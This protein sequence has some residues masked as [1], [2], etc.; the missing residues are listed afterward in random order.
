MSRFAV[1]FLL[2]AAIAMPAPANAATPKQDYTSAY[3]EATESGKPLVV[4]VGTD[5]C[6]GCVKMKKQ[7]IPQMQ[8]KGSLSAVKFTE[9]NAED[10]DQLAAKLMSGQSIPQLI[11]YVKTD[12]G[13]KRRQ[14]I[15]AKSVEEVETFING[16]L[17]KPVVRFSSNTK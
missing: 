5:W 6:P 1:L 12:A 11:M 9:V 10:E 3:K 2:V 8:T 14:L 4:L 7:V 16:N 15:G 17:E 13:W